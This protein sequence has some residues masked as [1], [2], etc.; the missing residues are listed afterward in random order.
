M[1]KKRL[2]ERETGEEKKFVHLS[3]AQEFSEVDL[4][5]KNMTIARQN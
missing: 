1:C 5:P 2:G 3:T 4:T